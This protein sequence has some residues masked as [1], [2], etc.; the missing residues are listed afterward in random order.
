[1][2][3]ELETDVLIVGGGSRA[4]ILLERLASVV[5]SVP[6]RALNVI[7]AEPG[8]LGPGLHRT[9]QGPYITFNSPSTCPTIFVNQRIPSLASS[10]RG[11]SFAEWLT[12]YEGELSPDFWP[13]AEAGRYLSWSAQ[14][15]L[16]NLP[17]NLQVEHSWECIVQAAQPVA[18][19]LTFHTDRSTTIRACAAVIAVGH[20]FGEVR[21]ERL[22]PGAG[23]GARIV[24]NPFPTHERLQALDARHTIAIR[25]LGLTALDV[26]AELTIGRGG[27][28]EPTGSGA[29]P[30]YIASGDEPRIYMYS[31]SSCPIRARP[32][33]SGGGS[34][35]FS[36]VIL[37]PDRAAQLL[38]G[39]RPI[40]F[41]TVVFPLILAEMAH[42]LLTG[43]VRGVVPEPLTMIRQWF[44]GG[45]SRRSN[46]EICA[47]FLSPNVNS[48]LFELIR[49][50]LRDGIPGT[51]DLAIA[52]LRDDIHES[53]LGISGSCLKYALEA[54]IEARVFVKAL[55]D[56]RHDTFSDPHWIFRT[57]PSLVNRNGIG[58]QT[59]KSDELL[60]LL[61]SGLVEIAPA[62][63][64]VTARDG[65]LVLAE[66]DLAD[67]IVV[68]YL[69]RADH[70]NFATPAQA[71]FIQ[72]L[73]STILALPILDAEGALVGL[74][75]DQGMRLFSRD[76]RNSLP[77][78]GTGPI[79]EGTA[80]YNGY[81]P[82]IQPDTEYPYFE[83]DRVARGIVACLHSQ[84]IESEP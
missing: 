1:M 34:T 49:P 15:F 28:F 8:V 61:G 84:Q 33:G 16:K 25:G 50:V 42:C 64:S 62:G 79:C 22:D 54:L 27:R 17:P 68:D 45:G 37:T 44:A 5:A 78:W 32:E 80:Y 13:R 12:T 70:V 72:S 39:H 76:Q 66:A 56:F 10:I 36:P 82:C 63:M 24:T 65:K 9:D 18:G 19:R 43:P 20:S 55:V 23:L 38:D 60:S 35:T 52:F 48:P 2:D 74:K 59:G 58:P 31:R 57:F 81:V 67:G 77:F 11:P 4:L 47:F 3:G 14:H 83:A 73:I 53:R 30:R 7:V 40:E 41:R 51:K 6:G 69:I 21:R 29:P 75:I 26:L 46:A 71:W